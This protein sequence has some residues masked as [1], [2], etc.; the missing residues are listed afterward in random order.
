[1]DLTY[2]QAIT[3]GIVEGLTEFLP[4][5]STGHM[6]LTAALLRMPTSEFLK[7]FEIVIQLGAILA[8]V[9]LYARRVLSGGMPFV[10]RIVAAF[11]P[12][13]VV[14]F[15]L[16]GLVKRM[17]GSPWV[18]V[19]ALAVGGAVLIL[20]E[21]YHRP[22]VEG[23]RPVETLSYR[24]A[25][26]LGLWQTLALVPGVSRSGATIVGGMLMGLPRT[27]VVEFTFLLAVPTMAAA[28]AV[29]LYR[30]WWTF[31]ADDVGVLAVGFI[32]AFVVALAAVRWF[33]GYVARHS[34]TA[35]GVYRIVAAVAAG[36]L[37][38]R[39]G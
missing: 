9:V 37:L 11:L 5:S 33:V 25:L 24:E 13:A 8:V 19:V 20:F 31:D 4:V 23:A 15:A 28:T 14:G 22:P 30:H 32:T 35:F 3:L 38:W 17:L 10:L 2:T 27:T 26:L 39:M 29:D 16:Y 1:M 18:V 6:I 12:T 7:S 34:F 21:R 36:L